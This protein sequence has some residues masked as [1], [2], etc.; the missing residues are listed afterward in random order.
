VNSKRGEDAL[1]QCH[2]E[3]CHSRWRKF[4]EFGLWRAELRSVF[5]ISLRNIGLRRVKYK[6]LIGSEVSL[7]DDFLRQDEVK[8]RNG[9]L[10]SGARDR[11]RSMVYCGRERAVSTA[12][13]QVNSVCRVRD[14]LIREFG[15]MARSQVGMWIWEVEQALEHDQARITDMAEAFRGMLSSKRCLH[16]S[17]FIVLDVGII[18]E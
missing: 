9:V 4:E 14:F 12:C 1:T 7:F 10:R 16:A 11:A 18:R 13:C 2:H 3:N 8:S 17:R 15:D 6:V 5:A